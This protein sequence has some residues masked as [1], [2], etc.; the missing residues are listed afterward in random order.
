MKSRKEV[1]GRIEMKTEE[2]SREQN[3]TEEKKNAEKS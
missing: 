2:N 3:K 1:K